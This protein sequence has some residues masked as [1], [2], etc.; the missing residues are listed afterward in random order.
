VEQARNTLASAQSQLEDTVL[1]APFAGIVTAVE[2]RASETVGTDSI[3]TL[4]DLD[5]PL[6]ELYLDETDLDKIA[7]G[8]E[9][10]VVF[11]ALPN[12]TFRGHVVQV[13]P[14]LVEV[15]GVTTVQALATLEEES[16]G[17]PRLLPAGLNASV[18]VIGG[19]A[20][21]ALLVPVEAL[22]ELSPGNY[23]VFVLVDGQLEARPVEVGLMDY[24]N[25]EIIS[26]L[27][28][29]DEVSTGIVETE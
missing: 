24:T 2:A 23:A 19:K 8:Y 26:G 5:H 18:D 11:D 25:A 12:E 21:N 10:E 15:D 6:I 14:T 28:Q 20:E 17:N 22:R 3:I 1:T 4:A 29:G 27:E 13:V 16:W 9:V 7:P